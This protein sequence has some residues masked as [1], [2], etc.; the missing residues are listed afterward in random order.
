MWELGINSF[1]IKESDFFV[2]LSFQFTTEPLTLSV[3]AI[4]GILV[5]MKPINGLTLHRVHCTASERII[6]KLS[7]GFN[8]LPETYI[9]SSPEARY[10]ISLILIYFQST[11]CRVMQEGGGGGGGTGGLQSLTSCT[12]FSR[13]QYYCGT[14]PPDFRPSWH[15]SRLQVNK[16]NQK[17][18]FLES[19]AK[20][21]NSLAFHFF[22]GRGGNFSRWT[23][24][25]PGHHSL[26]IDSNISP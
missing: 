23:L 17:S 4:C 6:R 1:L 7:L 16:M 3:L 5:T 12:T 11:L 25:R 13:L 26:T 19:C 15:Y 10:H 22:R 21:Y 14:L 8:A 20:T 9:F 24:Y 2:P 18:G